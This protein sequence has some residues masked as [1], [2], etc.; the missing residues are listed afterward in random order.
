MVDAS[1]RR[2]LELRHGMD[3]LWFHGDWLAL[4]YPHS[5][6]LLRPAGI[7]GFSRERCRQIADWVARA[8]GSQ[9]HI[10]IGT[11]PNAQE[12]IARRRQG[13]EDYPVRSSSRCV[14]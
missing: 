12:S 13:S 8:I 6:A 4:P 10:V 2:V 3:S 9:A 5:P 14:G 11:G 7:E 1:W